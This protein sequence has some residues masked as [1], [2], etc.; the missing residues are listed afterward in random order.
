M[1]KATILFTFAFSLFT[2]VFSFAQESKIVKTDTLKTA[3]TN[4]PN[5]PQAEEGDVKI[6]DGTNSLIRITDEG[7]FGAIEI[8]SGVPSATTDKLYNDAGTLKFNGSSLGGGSGATQLNELSDVIFEDGYSL[9]IGDGSGLLDDKTNNLNTSVGKN[10]LQFNSSGERNTAVGYE[11][12]IANQTGQR[13]TAI[14]AFSMRNNTTGQQNTAIGY[15][16]LYSNLTGNLNVALGED[17]LYSSNSGYENTSIGFSSL[18]NNTTG[19]RNVA[20]GHQALGSNTIGSGNVGIGWLANLGNQE[21]NNNT[22]IGFQAGGGTSFHNKNGNVFLGYQAGYNETGSDKLYIENSNSSSPLI[23]GDFVSDKVGINGKLGIGTTNPSDVLHVVGT[24]GQNG[25][26]VQV[27][28]ST[29]LRTF[30]NGGTSIG[31][32]NSGGTPP[33]GLYVHG[34]LNYNAALTSVSDKR[35]KNNI[36]LLENPLENISKIRGVTYNWKREEYP[37]RDFTEKKQIGVIAQ[38]V[39]AVFPELVSTNKD[40]Y[41]SVD[42]TKLTPILLEAVK[43]LKNQYSEL[44]KRLTNVEKQNSELKNLKE[45]VNNFV[46]KSEFVKFSNK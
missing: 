45:L 7:N 16:A 32:N 11:A 21:G 40:G 26:R 24:T 10:T 25:L 4:Q 44:E 20:V 14:G 9:Y 42:Y 15:Q 23:Y 1:N 8:K 27:G 36:K 30:S 3:N 29:K 33:D 28:N 35:Y 5:S 41:K 19:F 34:D 39:E 17:A 18:E 12:M 22:I 38:E 2:F 43:E 13:T 37:E 46:S 31:S 6:T